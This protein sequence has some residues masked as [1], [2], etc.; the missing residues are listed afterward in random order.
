MTINGEIYTKKIPPTE[1]AKHVLIRTYSAGVHFGELVRHDGMEVELNNARRIWSWNGA[2]TLSDIAEKGLK[3][4]KESRISLTV[5][6][7]ILTQAIEI[8][9][10]SHIALKSLNEV[11]EWTV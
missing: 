8:I 9:P 7:I 4:V 3:N 10:L 5:K 2:N 11:A 6:S 1:S